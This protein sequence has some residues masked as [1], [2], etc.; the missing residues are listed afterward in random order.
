MSR[1]NTIIGAGVLL[2]FVFMIYT[3]TKTKSPQNEVTLNSS[4]KVFLDS[5]FERKSD[6]RDSETWKNYKN[7]LKLGRTIDYILNEA[8]YCTKVK[9]YQNS[10]S[11]EFDHRGLPL[12]Q[13]RVV[14]SHYPDFQL[15][16]QVIN[17][18]TTLAN[19]KS[20]P[21]N[22]F[23]K[24]PI[25]R[26]EPS[27]TLFINHQINWHTYHE[28]GK[29]FLCEGQKY[30][31][32]PGAEQL[33]FKDVIANT[34][35]DYGKH[36]SG[37]EHCFNPWTFMPHTLDLTKTDQCQE[38]LE[39]LETNIQNPEIR[40]IMKKPRF[41]HSGRGVEVADQLKAQEI[42][43]S[44]NCPWEE[45]YI[46]QRYIKD[47]LLI[48]NHK[49]DFRV[50]MFVASMDPLIVMYHDGFVRL[51]MSEFDPDS[52]DKSVHL[53]NL[54]VVQSSMKNQNLTQE[55]QDLLLQD[56]S[57]SYSQFEN[58]MVQEGL[59]Q[60]GFVAS[61][62]NKMQTLMLHITRMNLKYFLRHPGVFELMGLDFIMDKNFNLWFLE[63]NL[64]PQISGTS[65]QKRNLNTQLTKHMIDLE[66]ALLYGAD[67][68][69]LAKDTNF[70]FVY[71]ERKKGLSKYHGLLTEDCL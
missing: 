4:N 51:S 45:L 65:Q 12:K 63:A 57:W 3:L 9:K 14:F 55:Q 11:V 43:S 23:K 31:H 22:F 37:R 69:S 19:T 66:Y 42:I 67:F 54:K 2:Y 20:Q 5:P 10:H 1:R 18:Y 8:A 39:D 25:E 41:F 40:W 71:D 16:K 26:F 29:H 64:S 56:Q 33:N 50:Y 48:N 47:P 49:F 70:E 36:Y 30:N 21:G 35:R 61:L 7:S 44:V 62:R 17:N 6:W 28:L 15:I 24:T 59:A 58:F 52:K 27:I 34:M 60:R 46:A 53:T 38:F 13:D 68:D 32:I